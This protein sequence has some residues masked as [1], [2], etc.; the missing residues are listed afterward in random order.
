LSLGNV[1]HAARVQVLTLLGFEVLNR[2]VTVAHRDIKVIE[3]E[4]I[5]RLVAYRYAWDITNW[6]TSG[7]TLP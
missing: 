5:I 4:Q 2:F 7:V 1:D 6:F 3:A